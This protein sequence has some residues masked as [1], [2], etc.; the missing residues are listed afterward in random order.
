MIHWLAVAAIVFAAAYIFALTY[1]KEPEQVS[2]NNQVQEQ[3]KE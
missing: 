2:T 1:E 3:I